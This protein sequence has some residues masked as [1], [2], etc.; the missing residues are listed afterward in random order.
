DICDFQHQSGR[1]A[2]RTSGRSGAGP[3][4]AS[5]DQFDIADA[6]RLPDGLHGHLIPRARDNGYYKSRFVRSV[7]GEWD[8]VLG[9][10]CLRFEGDA[11]GGPRDFFLAPEDVQPLVLLLLMLS[12]KVG[13]R[14]PPESGEVRVVPLRLDSVGLGEIEDGV[15]LRVVIGEI[16][17]AFALSP[18]M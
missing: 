10:V 6:L 18:G 14:R 7:S 4:A 13:V 5:T 8:P 15:V 2:G 16:A 11:V 12:G 9:R 3:V 17:L 1:C